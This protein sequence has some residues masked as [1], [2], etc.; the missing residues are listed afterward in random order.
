MSCD[1]RPP[2]APEIHS[3]GVIATNITRQFIQAAESVLLPEARKRLPTDA[4]RIELDIG[5][6][7][8]DEFF[9]LFESVGA[10]EVGLSLPLFAAPFF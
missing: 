4:N 8:K 1:D 7:I 2:P 3:K 5:Q 9:T 10:I 6:L